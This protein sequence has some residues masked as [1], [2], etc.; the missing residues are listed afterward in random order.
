MTTPI[1][2]ASGARWTLYHGDSLDIMRHLEAGA[3][4]A[5]VTDPPYS[6]G[7]FTRGDRMADPRSKYLRA[8]SEQ[9]EVLGNFGGDNRDQRA[10]LAWCG[11]WLSLALRVS[12]PGA[13]AGLFTDWRQLP[14][15]TDALQ[16]GG[17]VWRGIGQWIKTTCRPQKGRFA[18]AAEY[19]VWGSAGG[20]G[21][22]GNGVCAPGATW[23]EPTVLEGT[24]IGAEREHVTQKP[25]A[26]M[27][28]ALSIV[29]E[30][31]LVLDPFTGSGSTGVAALQTGR[32]FVGIEAERAYC[33]IAA[34]R[35]TEAERAA[36]ANL[37][38]ARPTATQ[39]GLFR[40]A[41]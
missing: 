11:L 27:R 29:P 5:L 8:D 41:R 30:G 23:E 37:F 26:V 31:G 35:L 40:G 6:S 7:G 4:D 20:M 3:V 16:V 12:K 15:T 21:A 38:T 18:A 13:I 14:T 10:Y 34:R 36:D 24:P 33:E 17:W 19:L 39:A 2:F 25:E 32:R 1:P 22:D 9:A 28:W